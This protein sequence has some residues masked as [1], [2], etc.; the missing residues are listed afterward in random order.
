MNGKLALTLSCGA[1]I[2]R[3][4][5]ALSLK[6][7]QYLQRLKPMTLGKHVGP[8]KVPSPSELTA[9]RGP[10]GSLSWPAVQSSPHLQASTS[11]LAG[12]VSNKLL[13]FAKANADV[14][15]SF[16]PMS[17]WRLVTAFDASFW[18]RADGTSPGGYFVLLAAKGILET[19]EDVYHILDWRS[20]K[21][22]RVARSSLAAESQ[23]A[24]CAAD[25]TEF[26][27]R[28]FEHL[29]KPHLKLADLLQVK[30][31]LQPDRC[32]MSTIHTTKNRCLQWTSGLALKSG[33]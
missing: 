16:E 33:W 11:M 25:A 27:C 21:L 29:L 22:P 5:D 15:L 3:D 1:S 13:K 2:K 31:S 14:G 32:Q 26:A 19:G 9:L 4:G 24:G 7:G 18:S 10:M 12:D 17:D 28:Y 6:H 20:F 8:E 23:A 30:S